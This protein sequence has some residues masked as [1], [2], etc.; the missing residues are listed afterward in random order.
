[1]RYQLVHRTASALLEA[2]RFHARKAVLVVHSF[3]SQKDGFEDFQ[4]FVKQL[5]GVKV[6]VGQLEPLGERSGIEL[7]VGWA[8]G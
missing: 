1:L 6:G 3:S 5:G 8:Q 4:L 7:F 2:K